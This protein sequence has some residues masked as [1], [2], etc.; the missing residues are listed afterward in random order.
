MDKACLTNTKGEKISDNSVL[1]ET[2][3]HSEAFLRLFCDTAAQTFNQESYLF[4]ASSGKVSLCFTDA[5]DSDLGVYRAENFSEF[6][7]SLYHFKKQ[8]LY[9]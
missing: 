9:E 5:P 6:M 2:V 3:P 1:I 4:K 8:C 7:S